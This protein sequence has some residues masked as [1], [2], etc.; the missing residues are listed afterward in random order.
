MK[1]KK[2][3]PKKAPTPTQSDAAWED[4]AYNCA[5]A[6]DAAQRT[7]VVVQGV[8]GD[9]DA[10]I[11][12]EIASILERVRDRAHHSLAEVLYV[13]PP[14]ARHS[15]KKELKRAGIRIRLPHPRKYDLPEETKP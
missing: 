15:L 3:K 4:L 8:R 12:E 5:A 10:A 7:L 11:V 14:E 9:K 13:L 1:Q 2:T 6:Q